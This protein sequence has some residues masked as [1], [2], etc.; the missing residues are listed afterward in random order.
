MS[1]SVENFWAMAT[2]N[3]NLNFAYHIAKDLNESKSSQEELLTFLHSVDAKMLNKYNQLDLTQEIDIIA[4]P[5]VERE[6][7]CST[8]ELFF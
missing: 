7:F 1:G 2:N 6:I 8:Y 5:V 4:A 3:D